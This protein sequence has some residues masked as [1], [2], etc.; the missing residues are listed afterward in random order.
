[1]A[2]YFKAGAWAVG[3]TWIC[4]KELIDKG[5]FDEISR[6]VKEALRIVREVKR[7]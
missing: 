7:G 2:E 1:M 4:K 5:D 6:L 3:G